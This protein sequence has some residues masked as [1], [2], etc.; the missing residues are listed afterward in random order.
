MSGFSEYRSELVHDAA[1]HAAIIMLRGLS[2]FCQ[3]ELIDSKLEQIVKGK[4]VCTFQC[5]RGRH[6]GSQ[7]HIAGKR[8]IESLDS[9]P[10]LDNLAA[11]SEDITCPTCLRCVFFAEAELYIIVQVDGESANFVRPVRFDFGYHAF[12]NGT[13]EN[14]TAIV[15]GVLANEVDASG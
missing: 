8:R 4:G 3:L 15:V 6:P 1:V 11:Y 13:G 12:I 10:A 5:G 7:W 9:T 2:D 14:E